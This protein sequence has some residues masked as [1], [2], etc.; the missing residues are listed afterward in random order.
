M[1]KT[2]KF[3]REHS[4]ARKEVNLKTKLANANKLFDIFLNKWRKKAIKNLNKNKISFPDYTNCNLYGNGGKRSDIITDMINRRL[5]FRPSIYNK[6][7]N[8]ALSTEIIVHLGKGNLEQAKKAVPSGINGDYFE[9]RMQE[10]KAL[11]ESKDLVRI[12]SEKNLLHFQFALDLKKM[13]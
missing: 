12:K 2:K 10:L 5:D 1:K 9:G 7:K 8:L 4:E 6:D 11:T 13:K 3:W